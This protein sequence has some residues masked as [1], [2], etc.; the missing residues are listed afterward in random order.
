MNKTTLF[1]IF[2]VLAFN[3][4]A[5]AVLKDTVTYGKVTIQKDRRIDMLGEKMLAYNIALTKNVRSGKGYRLML[6]TTNDRN[7]AMQLR[8]KL[9]QQFPEH[10]VYMVFQNPFIKLKMGNFTEREEAE[11]FRK[12]LLRIKMTPGNI[13][14]VPENIEIKPAKEEDQD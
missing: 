5:Q 9:L 3:L 12:Q 11:R 10:K 4:N 8:S 6:L 14:L 2:C 13:Y 1:T 7:L